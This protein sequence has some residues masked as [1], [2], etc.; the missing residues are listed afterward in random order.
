MV[1]GYRD[2]LRWQIATSTLQVGDLIRTNGRIPPTPIRPIEGDSYALGALPVGTEICLV[3]W[4]P[5]T[6]RVEIHRGNQSGKV[7]KRAGDRVIIRNTNNRDYSLHESCQC[8]VGK[9]MMEPLKALEIGSPNRLRWLGR[10]PSSGLRHR[11]T[12]QDGRKIRKPPPVE[13]VVPELPPKDTTVVL[14]MKT[15]GIQG[16]PRGR[17]RVPCEPKW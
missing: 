2:K 15:E 4:L 9:V 12:G 1:T 14:H 3:Q 8:V 17:L 5:G 11:K 7:L 13:E 10:Q 6:D 16:E